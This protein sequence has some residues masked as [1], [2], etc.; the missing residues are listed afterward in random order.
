LPA[1]NVTTALTPCTDP[2][3][4]NSDCR[5]RAKVP[6]LWRTSL[7]REPST[8]VTVLSGNDELAHRP[9]RC[10]AIIR[11]SDSGAQPRLT[12]KVDPGFPAG[13]GPR[14]PHTWLVDRHG[15]RRDDRPLPVWSLPFPPNTFGVLVLA[16]LSPLSELGPGKRRLYGTAS[17]FGQ[18]RG[19]STLIGGTAPP[20]TSDTKCVW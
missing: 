19:H 8:L 17:S 5:S 14:R 6:G 9:H 12:L 4:P 15:M 18:G 11:A 1:G 2:H 13:S 10:P 20:T 16:D 3:T 7:P